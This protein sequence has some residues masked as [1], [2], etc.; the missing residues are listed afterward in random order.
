MCLYPKY[1]LKKAKHD[2]VCYK[3]MLNKKSNIFYSI[4]WNT[5]E[6]WYIGEF[7]KGKH[8]WGRDFIFSGEIGS[9]YIH[10]YKDERDAITS[11]DD[12]LCVCKCIIPKGSYYYE[13]IHSD[14]KYGYA[15]KKL[16]IV[17]KL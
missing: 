1:K 5:N 16:K 9:G 2:I 7:K 15:S 14:G 12:F 8:V 3:V 4:Y 6:P 13:G 10:S 11:C 17:K